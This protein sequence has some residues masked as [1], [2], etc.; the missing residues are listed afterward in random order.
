LGEPKKTPPPIVTKVFGNMLKEL[1]I[2]VCRDWHLVKLNS[3]KICLHRG[4][5]RPIEASVLTTWNKF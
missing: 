4:Q 2:A 1:G 5:Q 3:M